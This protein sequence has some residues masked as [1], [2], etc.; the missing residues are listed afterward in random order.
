MCLNALYMILLK[1][2]LVFV[3]T[4]SIRYYYDGRLYLSECAL[5]D[6]IKMRVYMCQNAFYMILLKW[7]RFICYYYDGS[8]YLSAC[9]LNDVIK[10]RACMCLNALYMILLKW[11]L[12]FVWTRFIWYF[13]DGRLYLSECAFN[14]IIKMRACMSECA[15]HGITKIRF[16]MCLNALYMILLKWELVFVWT[17]C[18]CYYYDSRLYLSECALKDII[19]MCLNSLYMILLKLDFCMCLNALYMILLKW[20]LVF[21]WT[22]FIW[23]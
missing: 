11:E 22:C 18:I 14:F 19:K 17:L 15:L 7:T 3:W 13:Y 6:V 23:Y 12:V 10:L 4:R 1:W 9:A 20:E 16:S 2:E 8:L 21:V 5:K